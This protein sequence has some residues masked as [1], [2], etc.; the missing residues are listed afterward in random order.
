MPATDANGTATITVTATD[1]QATN[2]TTTRAFTVTVTAV[3]DAPTISAFRDTALSEDGRL[4]GLPFAVDE[5]GGADED[6]QTLTVT[7]TSSNAALFPA[8]SVRVRYTPDGT[9][10]ATGG[11]LDLAPAANAS[12]TAII[13]LSVSDGQASN[14]TATRTFTVTV[15]P[16]NDA[17]T[18]S[19]P[20][21]QTLAEDAGPQTFT[22]SSGPG[23]GPDEVG[24]AV[25]VTA[26]SSNPAVIP[27]P[28]IAGNTL[29]YA[30]A[31]DA[32]G[33]ATITLTASDGQATNSTTSRT[34]TVTVT[35]AND[36][37]TLAVPGAQVL[38][39]DGRLAGLAFTV[40]EGG[41]ADEDAQGLT[42][43]ATSSN[44][45]LVPA[46]SLRVWYSADG[47]TDATGGT[48]DLA[49][50][51]NASGIATITL[52]VSD[53]QGS[54]GT[55]SG[56]FTV[57]VTPVND[58]PTLT[59]PADQTLPEDA[60]PQTL[61]V[62]FGPGGGADEAGQ[63][64]TVTAT[65][66]APALIPH[67][68]VSGTGLSY[69][70]LPD[71]IGSATI[72]VT[73]N[74]GQSAN[75]TT[76]RTFTV[77]VTPVNDASTM[78]ALPDTTLSEDGH[79]VGLPFTV[80]EGGGPDE[81]GQALTV[82]ATSSNAGLF[83]AD[84]L[85]VR[86][87]PDG[88]ADATGGTL[89]LAPVADASGT[90]TI[91]LTVSDG[92]S[93]SSTATRTFTVTV[94]PVNDPPRVTVN[95]GLT[96]RERATAL[97]T[98]AQLQAS[99]VD[100]PAAQLTYTVLAVPERGTLARSG[101]PLA[102]NGR[103]TQA[104]VDNDLIAYT[105]TAGDTLPDRFTFTVADAPGAATAT[106]AFA[107]T[108]TPA[109]RPI[110]NPATV[111]VREDSLLDI[112][113][114]GSDP[115]GQPLTFR[116]VTQPGYADS[117]R[118]TGA[119]ATSATARYRPAADYNGADG[120]TFTV[121][122]GL[123]TS[124]PASVAVS[125]TPVNDAPRFTP[126]GD[127]TVLEDAGPQTVAGWATALS[128]GPPD[129]A[130]QQLTFRVSTPD[131]A[132]FAVRPSLDASGTLSFTPA[133]EANGRATVSVRLRDSGGTAAG[134]VDT[135]AASPFTITVTPVNDPPTLS[136]PR[137]TTL[138][139]DG[140]LVGLAFTVDEGGG[141]DEDAQSLTVTA[142]SSNPALL[143]PDSLWVRYTP[144][145]AADATG[146]T[147]DLAPLANA[148]ATAMVTLTVADGVGL[149]STSRTFTLTVT[150]VN[151]NP[152]LAA[153]PDTS[154]VEGQRLT[155]ALSATDV[156]GDTL[157][158]SAT[159][160]PAGASLVGPAFSWTPT[161]TQAG[162]YQPAFTVR[163]GQ[164]GTHTRSAAIAVRDTLPP[165]LR[166]VPPEWE[167]GDIP[168]RTV[169]TR[170]FALH[171]PGTVAVRLDSLGTR[172]PAFAVTAPGTPLALGPGDS[173]AVAIRFAPAPRQRASQRDTLRV[174]SSVGAVRVPLSGRGTWV[175]LAVQPPQLDFG[176]V[177]VGGS[178]RLPLRVGNPGNL[179]LEVSST[180]VSVPFAATP[181]VLNVLPGAAQ[182][183]V[184]TYA[185][186]LPGRHEGTLT[187]GSN[188]DSVEVVLL[189]GEAI[190]AR[191]AVSP[192]A[193][194]FGA[195]P[196]DSVAV[197]GL[198]LRSAGT[199]TLRV[200]SLE[201]LARP[202]TGAP[203]SVPPL[204]PGDSAAVK[205][206]FAPA[207]TGAAA[208]TL[209]VDSNSDGGPVRVP[210]AG[211]GALVVSIDVPDT[212]A[213]G[214]V[215]VGES[216]EAA[217]VVRNP[218]TDTLRIDDIQST[219]RRFSVTPTRLRVG[220]RGAASLAVTFA[221]DGEGPQ[222]GR[223]LFTGN[224]PVVESA[225]T[226]S[227]IVSSVALRLQP[228]Y[229]GRVWLGQGR[230]ARL[231]VRNDGP[232][233]ALVDSV[234]LV[235]AGVGG[236]SLSDLAV[237]VTPLAAGDS[238]VVATL[239]FRPETEGVLRG[240][241][242]GVVGPGIDG[243]APVQ[244][245]GIRPPTMALYEAGRLLGA[246]DTVALDS[247]PAGE[248]RARLLEVRNTGQ[249]TLR[250][251]SV[252]TTHPTFRAQTT[253]LALA[254]GQAADL[255][256]LFAPIQDGVT[257]GRLLLGSNDPASPYRLSLRG[258]TPAGTPIMSYAPADTLLFAA[259]PPGEEGW[260]AAPAQPRAGAAAGAAPV[261]RF[262]L[263]APGDRRPAPGRR[264]AARGADPVRA[265][266]RGLAAGR[267]GAPLQ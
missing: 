9:A 254:P 52:T 229:L 33:S 124:S 41:G 198:L 160:L 221:P 64:V 43:S 94:T 27:D 230:S 146:G 7:A 49:P 78:S 110:A 225:L 118:L 125:V 249:D 98:E 163:D 73:A 206:R 69:T 82:T 169:A 156:D 264:P 257:E 109:H 147:L 196:V 161:Y 24:Q 38:A 96:L 255:E 180:E 219:N 11:T 35:A 108:V 234:R 34:F 40:D 5:G 205:V 123:F 222:V 177:A 48:L 142:T 119:T 39:E 167:V 54:G 183:V 227:G 55:V 166:A 29:S 74:D 158:F 218:G 6:S 101:T 13:T 87:T 235:P 153:L 208:D 179:R 172:T 105:H 19:A 44:P 162:T 116:V 68:T 99:D 259:V 8:D 212:V 192:S 185:P 240:V 15:A 193:L 155:F 201:G 239:W 232:A 85:R 83:P 195:V 241:S 215:R 127:R 88:A 37:P 122:N 189:R 197:Q 165:L 187:L 202:F 184:V 200:T 104:D 258:S 226:G 261:R 245:T 56:S 121:S 114:T 217:V 188:A 190:Q 51:A 267:P 168:D 135:S 186:V 242:V 100:H 28:T 174:H 191:L 57:T 248:Q 228:P 17:P 115:A 243:A 204:A 72:T 231:W 152:V 111:T 159:G 79:L 223:L 36:A 120:F 70:P 31:A 25:T 132:L 260:A 250:I 47:P 154:I 136:A 32:S 149:S 58:A 76:M 263:C 65:S 30:P 61:T 181:R 252:A 86:Y 91:T 178:Q 148:S 150:P 112:T 140:R 2:S 266:P 233:V 77:T 262:P 1:G 63:A 97:I 93:T 50:A 137:D 75:S 60:G 175:G 253:Q 21:D 220:P 66:S 130:G 216:S 107:I 113:L 46:D 213:F 236:L 92:Q 134:G 126:G 207:Q 214:D 244:G 143:P 59:A 42:V 176:R 139:E 62:S 157:A 210:V 117:L 128:A 138:L 90:A 95:Q 171:N 131:T 103:F 151:D 81:D 102:R 199:D 18:L 141:P 237:P 106:T 265:R 89:D 144:D 4:A 12:G 173:V 3:N 53:G 203:A 22:L 129:E 14:S 20:A 23:G 80:D 247:V 209:V 211:S 224:V 26:V 10:D 164:G 145:G 45:A 194:D 133:P 182:E 16:V 246:Q 67:P 256:V 170:T 238:V 84:S 251:D 71:A